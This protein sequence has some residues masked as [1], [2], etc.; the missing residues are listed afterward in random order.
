MFQ[1]RSWLPLINRHQPAPI[2]RERQPVSQ[3][4][5]LLGGVFCLAGIILFTRRELATAQGNT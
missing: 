3:I 2:S 1:R 5:L 4:I